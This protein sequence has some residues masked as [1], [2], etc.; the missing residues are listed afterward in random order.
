MVLDELVSNSRNNT[1]F[2]LHTRRNALKWLIGKGVQ[3][4]RPVIATF[5]QA[6]PLFQQRLEIACAQEY[7]EWTLTEWDPSRS[8]DSI[9]V[10]VWFGTT[11]SGN[12]VESPDSQIVQAIHNLVAR[13]KGVLLSMCPW[14]FEQVSVSGKNSG[15]C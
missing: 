13:G 7:K 15:V 3:G 1:P 4:R 8:P 2:P 12:V 10:L 9:D 14:G 6:L 11:G 5:G